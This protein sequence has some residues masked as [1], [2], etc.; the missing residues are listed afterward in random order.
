MD[1]YDDDLLEIWR[2]LAE[3]GVSYIMVGGVATNLHGYNRSTR[4][5]DFYFEDTPD[6]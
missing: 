5:A 3:H 2:K 1:I 6:N 4:D